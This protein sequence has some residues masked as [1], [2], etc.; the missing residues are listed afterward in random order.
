MQDRLRPGENPNKNGNNVGFGMP[1]SIV[2]II[3]I[4]LIVGFFNGLSNFVVFIGG[5]EEALTGKTKLQ[6]AI[7]S[8]TLFF[9]STV[10]AFNA[11]RAQNRFGSEYKATKKHWKDSNPRANTVA[12]FL[13]IELVITT[14]LAV[15]AAG[16]HVPIVGSSDSAAKK[17]DRKE[18][19]AP[20][21]AEEQA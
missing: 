2:D 10:Y 11:I 4:S 12:A 17:E 16:V 19:G 7:L 20:P 21:V 13:L 8:A 5:G 1:G 6:A 9:F 14:I 3:T 15:L 18:D